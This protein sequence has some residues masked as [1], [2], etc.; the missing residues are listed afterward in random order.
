MLA[1]CPNSYHCLSDQGGARVDGM[2]GG[3]RIAQQPWRVEEQ[4]R[5]VLQPAVDRCV[6]FV[7]NCGLYPLQQGRSN[8]LELYFTVH[9]AAPARTVVLHQ[10][11]PDNNQLSLGGLCFGKSAGPFLL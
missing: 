1:A 11:I 4:E 6:C 5:R 10:L 2:F 3:Y 8:R 9:N 7:E